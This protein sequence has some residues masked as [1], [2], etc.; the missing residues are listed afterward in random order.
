L[1]NACLFS[2]ADE[3]G[4]KGLAANVKGMK[5]YGS[6]AGFLCSAE[7]P[8]RGVA[9]MENKRWW[10]FTIVRQCSCGMGNFTLLDLES[11][12]TKRVFMRF[13]TF[14]SV[15]AAKWDFFVGRSLAFQEHAVEFPEGL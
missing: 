14:R 13:C 5:R 4:S 1:R 2:D 12:A 9:V 11:H 7:V 6:T 8:V 10:L 3:R 15:E